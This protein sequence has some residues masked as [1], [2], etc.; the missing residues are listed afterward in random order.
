M[1]YEYGNGGLRDCA[2]PPPWSTALTPRRGPRN[3]RPAAVP[4]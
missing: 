2:K 3:T 4:V 1:L